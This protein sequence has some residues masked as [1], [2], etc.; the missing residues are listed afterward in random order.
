M[1]AYLVRRLLWLPV[2]LVV[3][4]LIT[5]SLGY[6]GPADPIAALLGQRYDPEIASGLAQ[7]YGL[8]QP[9]IVQFIHYLERV[10]HLDFGESIKYRNQPVT[11]LLL[12]R[13]A[14]TVQINGA[15]QSHLGRYVVSVLRLLVHTNVA[16]V[17][18]PG[19][20]SGG[21]YSSF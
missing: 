2:L 19:Q 5:F 9:F 7:E 10:V 21:D 18:H 16:A 13:L 17:V 6:Y 15:A 12:P 11:R 8:D 20:H 3:V 14:V 4:A 1:L